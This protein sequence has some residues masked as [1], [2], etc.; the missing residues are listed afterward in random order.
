ME[1]AK[2]EKDYD[3]E[4]LNIFKDLF[5]DFLNQKKSEK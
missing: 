2:I 5:K 3:I 1:K 4:S